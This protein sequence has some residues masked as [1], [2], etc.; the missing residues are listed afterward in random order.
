MNLFPDKQ[1]RLDK[2]L[3]KAAT[4]G[5]AAKVTALL[6]AGATLNQLSVDGP[7]FM[8][9]LTGDTPKYLDVIGLLLDRGADIDLVNKQGGTPLMAAANRGH[10]NA[11]RLLLSKGADHTLKAHD[12]TA[13]DWSLASGSAETIFLMQAKQQNTGATDEVTLQRALGNRTLEEVFNFASRERLTMIRVYPQGPVEAITRQNF[14]D[15]DDRSTLRN[16]FAV[17]VQQGGK[18]AES[19]IFPEMLT[20]TRTPSGLTGGTL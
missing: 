17:Y 10:V 8:A 5:D 15:I 7:L 19:E 2:Q 13:F 4:A 14:R 9:A 20:K 18:R 6:D 16:A 1:K 12:K 3:I 11:A